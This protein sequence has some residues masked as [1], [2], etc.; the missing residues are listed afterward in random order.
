VDVYGNVLAASAFLHG[1]AA[2]EL[3]ADELA[4][5]D[6]AYQVIVGVRAIKPRI[7]PS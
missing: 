6:A 5:R 4:R 2:H 1:M 7:T 3:R